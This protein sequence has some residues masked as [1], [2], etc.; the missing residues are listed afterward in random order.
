MNNLKWTVSALA[1]LG[2]ACSPAA[3][4]TH[5]GAS[6]FTIQ[7]ATDADVALRL[8]HRLKGSAGSYGFPAL[9]EVAAGVEARLRADACADLSAALAPLLQSIDQVRG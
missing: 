8:A 9:G 5:R 3:E 4:P 7:A 2:V 6:H 1:L